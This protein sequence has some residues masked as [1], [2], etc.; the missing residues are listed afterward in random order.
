M[1]ALKRSAKESLGIFT[2][3][4]TNTHDS[5]TVIKVQKKRSNKMILFPG[6][7]AEIPSSSAG[8]RC[9]VRKPEQKNF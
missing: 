6:Y 2:K 8:F 1:Y 9:T 7:L 5:I 3:T 4:Y